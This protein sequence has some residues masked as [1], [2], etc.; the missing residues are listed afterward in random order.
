MNWSDVVQ[1]L[2]SEGLSGGCQ[3]GAVRFHVSR[4]L[5]SLEFCHCRMCQKAFG[6]AGAALVAAAE[7]DLQWTRGRPAEFRSSPVVARGFC[8]NCGT[9][10]YMR[11]DGDPNYELAVGAFDHPAKIGPPTRQVGVESRLPWFAALHSLPE[12]STAENRRPEDLARL[13]TLQHPDRDTEDWQV[14]WLKPP[15]R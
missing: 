14:A 2:G 7:A 11:E 3:C 6:A 15:Q 10:L 9:P 5:G 12:Q 8:A 13:G 1:D 4:E